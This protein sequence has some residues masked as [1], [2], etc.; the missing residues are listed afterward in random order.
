MVSPIYAGR[1]R[2]VDPNTQSHEP[3]LH[4]GWSS[5]QALLSSSGLTYRMW[6][7]LQKLA[8]TSFSA[9][10]GRQSLPFNLLYCT[11]G[12]A[13]RPSRTIHRMALCTAH[14]EPDDADKRQDGF[15]RRGSLL[16]SGTRGSGLSRRLLSASGRGFPQL[17]SAGISPFPVACIGV[18]SL[19]GPR[20][21]P[22]ARYPAMHRSPTAGLL[23]RLISAWSLALTFA[24]LE[25][26]S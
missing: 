23:A 1:V 20:L 6:E 2:M 16:P 14:E 22:C 12:P 3:S 4:A 8:I 21:F 10:N 18:A 25:R 15:C 19:A 24:R 26:P 5:R 7:P 17:A 11:F 9:K 13:S